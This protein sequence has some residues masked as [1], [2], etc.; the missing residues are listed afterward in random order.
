MKKTKFLIAVYLFLGVSLSVFCQNT[1]KVVIPDY[2]NYP[3][4]YDKIMLEAIRQREEYEQ[5]LLV[6]H[7]PKET[8]KADLPSFLQKVN[9]KIGSSGI[10]V[11]K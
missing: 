11:E 5:E 8:L 6:A 4:P 9:V 10:M 2:T 3:P 7:L 1:G